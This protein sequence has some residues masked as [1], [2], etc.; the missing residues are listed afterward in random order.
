MAN[1]MI[2]VIGK[3]KMGTLGT[4]DP[5]P[6]PFIFKQLSAK[7]CK[8][9]AWCLPSEILDLPSVLL[10]SCINFAGQ[11]LADPDRCV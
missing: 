3:S 1:K 7:N 2:V 10:F 11:L 6:I 5:G 8:I 4:C 9:L